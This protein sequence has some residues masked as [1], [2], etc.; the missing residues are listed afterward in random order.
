MKSILYPCLP[1]T[2]SKI[3]F[4]L[5]TPGTE[6]KDRAVNSLKIASERGQ[7]WFVR[8]LFRAIAAFISTCPVR[9]TSSNDVEKEH[10]KKKEKKRRNAARTNEPCRSADYST[11]SGLSLHFVAFRSHTTAFYVFAKSRFPRRREEKQKK[12]FRYWR[13]GRMSWKGH[14]LSFYNNKSLQDS[15]C[16]RAHAF[17]ID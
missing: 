9:A 6:E 4:P 7:V 5:S 12:I 1:F 14:R 3:L 8:R 13:S 2:S 11:Y 15:P 16:K 17:K 10:A